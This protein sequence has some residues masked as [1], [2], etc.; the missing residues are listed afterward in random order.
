M[1]N[2]DYLIVAAEVDGYEGQPHDAG[3]VHREA[4]ELRF[5]KV[6]R[7]ITCLDGVQRAHDD[8]EDVEPERH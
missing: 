3:R 5:V 2:Y 6:L 7:Q 4:D 8:E 1:Y